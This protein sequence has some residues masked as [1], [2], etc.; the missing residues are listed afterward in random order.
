MA[1][2]F[3]PAEH[4]KKL[5]EDMESRTPEGP[6]Q[7]LLRYFHST[8]KTG[9][10]SPKDYS[11]Y[12]QSIC[13]NNDMEGWHLRLNPSASTTRSASLPLLY[14]ESEVVR[15]QVKLVK[16]GKLARYQRATYRRQPGRIFNLWDKYEACYLTTKQL[17]KSCSHLTR[18]TERYSDRDTCDRDTWILW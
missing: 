10:W 5:Y 6:C 18:P 2:P 1:L 11:V 14:K 9:N 7:D 12:G 15:R 13:T 8:W 4:V 3:I 17:P 16:Q